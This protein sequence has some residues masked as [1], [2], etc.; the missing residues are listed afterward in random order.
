[1]LESIPVVEK[2]KDDYIIFGCNDSYKVIPWLDE[3]YA[4]DDAWW[5]ENGQ[6]FRNKYPNLSSWTQ[7]KVGAENW[8]INHIPGVHR[9]GLS[10]DS[11]L[12]HFGSNSGYQLLNLAFL[13]GCNKFI[14][15]GYNMQKVN[16]KSHFFGDHPGGLNKKSPYP[17]FLQAFDRVQ[18]QIKKLIVNCTPQSALMCF[19]NNDLEKELKND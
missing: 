3:H 18:P 16:G 10:L 2:Y 5:S 15:V 9:S 13:M 19:K 8:H 14:L 7:S 11:D 17:K 12:I 1:M 4:C 6:D